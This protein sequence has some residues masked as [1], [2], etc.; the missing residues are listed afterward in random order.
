M[1]LN[2]CFAHSNIIH[3]VIIVGDVLEYALQIGIIT[4]IIKSLFEW[5]MKFQNRGLKLGYANI[6]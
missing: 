2:R 1:L 5:F 6:V 3:Q 4:F